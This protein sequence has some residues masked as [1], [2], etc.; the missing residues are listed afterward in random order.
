MLERVVERAH[1]FD[2]VHFHLEHV[3]LP[4][5]R[6][7]PV[8]SLTTQHGRLDLPG[9][10]ELY[11]TF[12]DAPL[13]SISDAQRAPLRH[14]RWIG[15]VHHGL[16]FAERTFEP[17]QDG[18][19]LVFLGRLSKEKRPDLAIEIAKRSGL[20]LKIAAKIG[21]DDRA[22]V[23]SI[24]PL[25]EH[26]LVHVIGEV[27]E[28]EKGPLLANATA[29]LFPIDW[30]EPFGLVM[31]EAMARGTPV[32]A[33]PRGSVPEVVDDGVTGFIV[34]T[35][36]AAVEAV[37]RAHELDRARIRSVAARRFSATAMARAYVRLYE[38]LAKPAPVR[39][40]LRRVFG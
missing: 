32:I 1:D 33:F 7:L 12:S 40:P 3:H 36:D 26:P 10:A 11:R 18:G 15:T 6:R 37:R 27:G 39:A 28:R 20:P 19:Y 16:P 5:A 22:Y 9:L 34:E 13:V 25:L 35:V 23:R 24:G 38:Q 29:L 8:P 17:G 30:P 14:A 31:I 2:V 4:V 21:A